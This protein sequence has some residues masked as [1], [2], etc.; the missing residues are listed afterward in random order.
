V[1][2]WLFLA[3][4]AAVLVSPAAGA[5]AKTPP[6]ICGTACDGGGGGWTGCTSAE[7]V[8]WSGVPYISNFHHHLLLNY[9]KR[10]GII[11][12][13]NI[14]HYCT[15]DGP[16]VCSTGPAWLTGGGVGSG[17][18]TATGVATYVGGLY[19]VPWAGTST[20]NVTIGWG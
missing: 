1:R 17:Y 7:G 9:C 5:A 2:N 19:G 10:N 6:V 15:V 18:A 13:L 12:A 4:L 11:T 8:D 3:A 20:V 16:V 14:V